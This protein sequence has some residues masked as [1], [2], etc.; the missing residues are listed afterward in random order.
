MLPE[1]FH[2]DCVDEGVRR[3]VLALNRIPEVDT[4][5]T[6][7]GHVWRDTLAWPT[8]DGWVHFLKPDNLHDELIKRIQSY[9]EGNR[10]FKIGKPSKWRSA[11]KSIRTVSGM[12][13]SH[14]NGGLF[15]RIS[16]EEQEKYFE[17]ADKRKIE[18]LRGWNEL[19]EVTE[20]YIIE[21][22][23]R[24]IESLPYAH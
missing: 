22:I 20:N 21:N 12:F 14:E 24:D 13:E 1:G 2:L 17:R 19:G 9:C 23:S 16:N 4:M 11:T 5:T 10:I 7:E 15:D 3:F 6:C 18:L 8:K